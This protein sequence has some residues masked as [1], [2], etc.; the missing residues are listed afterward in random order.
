MRGKKEREKKIGDSRKVE[1][2]TVPET[3]TRTRK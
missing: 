1:K 3:L 2:T